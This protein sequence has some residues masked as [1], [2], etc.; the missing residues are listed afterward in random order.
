[1]GYCKV[2]ITLLKQTRPQPPWNERAGVSVEP[3]RLQRLR[4]A[5]GSETL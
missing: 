5:D 1:M 3:L 2:E 4:R